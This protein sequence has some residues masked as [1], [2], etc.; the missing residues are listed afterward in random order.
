MLIEVHVTISDKNVGN[1]SFK[2]VLEE[3]KLALVTKMLCGLLQQYHRKALQSTLFWE[4]SCHNFGQDASGF[5]A[6][7]APVEFQVCDRL[8]LLETPKPQNN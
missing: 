5:D 1:K 3:I 8:F 2:Q 6:A 4:I 7:N